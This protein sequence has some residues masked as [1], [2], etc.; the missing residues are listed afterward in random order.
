[1]RHLARIDATATDC[2]NPLQR[3]PHRRTVLITIACRSGLLII[4][5]GLISIACRS[6]LLMFRPGLISIA[7]LI[8]D[9]DVSGRNDKDPLSIRNAYVSAGNDKLSL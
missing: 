2:H 6:G 8:R 3:F 5:A 1:M 4:R 7:Y 9:G